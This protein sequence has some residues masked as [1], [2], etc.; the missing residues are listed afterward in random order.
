MQVSLKL[1]NHYIDIQD[2]SALDLA[3]KITSIGH[4]VEGIE[5]LAVGDDLVVGLVKECVDHPDS[6]HLHVCQVQVNDNDVFQIVCGAPNVQAGQKVIVALPGC[7][8]K[9]ITI[10]KSQIRGVESNGMICSL[11]ELGLDSRFVT[12]QQKAGIEVLDQNA[13]LGADALD[14]L[15]LKDDILDIGLTPNRAD[16]MALKAFAYEVGAILKRDIKPVE[17][18]AMDTQP[19]DV[20]IQV[21]TDKCPVFGIKVVKGVTTKESPQWLKA[22]LMA[23]GIKPINNIVDISNLIMLETGQ[24]IHMYDYDKIANKTFTIKDN[25]QSKEM[26][27][28]GNEYDVVQGDIVIEV[29]GKLGCL[30]GVMG[31]EST[32]ITDDSV[33]IA[34][35]AATFDGPSLRE[36]ARRLN[37]L[38]D[39]SQHYIKGS[40]DSAKT[41]E[42]LDRVAN[43]LVEYADAKEI[44]E[45]VITPYEYEPTEL[46]LSVED[47]NGLLGTDISLSE[48][49]DIFTDLKFDYSLDGNKLNIAIPSY[50][51]DITMVAD[52]IEEVA[53]IHGYDNIPSCLPE[54]GTTIGKRSGEQAKVKMIKDYLSNVALHE[55]ITYTLSSPGKADDFNLFHQGEQVKLMF[56][57]GEERSVVRKSLIPS[58]LEVVKYNVARKNN[59]VHIFEISNTY[60]SEQEIQTLAIACHGTYMEQSF[61]QIR[62]GADYL[63]VKGFVETILD[64]LAIAPSRYSLVRVEKE[65]EFYH[66]GRSAY[67]KMGKDIIGVVG[68]IHPLM[69]KKYDVKDVYVCELNLAAL[70]TMKTPNLKAGI[71]PQYPAVMRDVAF[72]MAK[73]VYSYDVIRK[74]VQA[75]KGLATNVTL[76][77]EY[78]GEHVGVGEK[79]VAFKV[80]LQDPKKTLDENTINQT[81][82][83][84]IKAVEKQF[85]ANLRK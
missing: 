34:I 21:E 68:C 61:R 66:P 16:C 40:I 54:M 51:K 8:L 39:A 75:S 15:G 30:A 9:E 42:V 11:A 23:S 59:D 77:D 26:F 70:L 52:L 43:L 4:E 31:G 14:Y 62:H 6:D 60:S 5:T 28:D 22:A 2:Q 79:S 38:T 45:T 13:P 46:A 57:L 58:L 1:L 56:P 55:T 81:M 67:I 49:R 53:R 25:Y 7:E 24:P 41:A 71:I 82:E 74:I 17:L 47:V 64:K 27:L 48:I 44:Q 50:R 33:N 32:K 10:K 18:K 84:I 29:D 63:L 20:K 72:V 69:A 76:F 37:L 83:N 80:M 12:E 78:M 3:A 65:N 35:E 85:K 36:T 19:G 73:D